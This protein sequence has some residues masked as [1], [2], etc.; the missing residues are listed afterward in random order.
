[1]RRIVFLLALISA[2]QF[3][4]CSSAFAQEVKLIFLTDEAPLY[5]SQSTNSNVIQRIE[6]Q[7][8]IYGTAIDDKWFMIKLEDGQEAFIMSWDVW[9]EAELS[10]TAKRVSPSASTLFRMMRYFRQQQRPEKAEEFALR[11]IQQHNDDVYPG[12]GQECY[13]LGHK[14]YI[15]M[16]GTE[17]TGIQ[18]DAFLLGFTAKVIEEGKDDDL[19]AM[20]YYHQAQF[21]A[22]S[23]QEDRALDCLLAIVDR[24]PK[25][26]SRNA[27][28]PEVNTTAFYL[29]QRTKYLFCDL[30]MKLASTER[31]QAELKVISEDGREAS[32]QM[33]D[34]LLINLGNNPYQLAEGKWN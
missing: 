31:V 8:E 7:A 32:A 27:C 28:T 20:A 29:P 9:P 10:L 2:G 15:E 13:K 33:A 6:N 19:K 30:A 26:A 21:Y 4:F 16:L 24:F 12:E 11:I 22:R 17:D 18:Y 34:E 14:A 3:I 25:A 5:E 23:G 1:M